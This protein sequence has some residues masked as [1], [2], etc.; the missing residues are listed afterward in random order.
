MLI[1]L[2]VRSSAAAITAS[3]VSAGPRFIAGGPGDDRTGRVMGRAG[4]RAAY[5]SCGPC[6]LWTVVQLRRAVS[7]FEH[8]QAPHHMKLAT[9][10]RASLRVTNLRN[11]S[12][13][14]SL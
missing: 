2:C 10:A 14:L 4:C 13:L 3:V 9:F 5:G 1:A 6:G 8:Q 11:M 7:G 12:L